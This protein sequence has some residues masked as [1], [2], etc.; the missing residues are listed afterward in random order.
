MNFP[1]ALIEK[2]RAARHIV[3][4]TGAGVSAVN[5]VP[6]F[7][8]ALT[9][10][11]QCFNAEELATRR[12]F[13]ADPDLVWS[14]Y[15]WRRGRGD[16]RPA[17]PGPSRDRRHR[18]AGAGTDRHHSKRG[19]SPRTRAA[20]SPSICTAACFAC[21]RPHALG[22]D[23]LRSP[24]AGAAWRRRSA[25]IAAGRCAQASSG[26]VRNCRPMPGARR[27]RR[28]AAAMCSSASAR[29]S[30]SILRQSYR[31]WRPDAAPW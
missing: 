20:A 16:A 19:R 2:L 21:N 24:R 25:C 14:W 15:E 9:G 17:L 22:P 13:K 1:P 27:G 7:R 29:R 12:A 10:L 23:L 6:T 8:D 28:S 30:L 26:S 4:F 18:G 3:V 11:W 5:G 31:C